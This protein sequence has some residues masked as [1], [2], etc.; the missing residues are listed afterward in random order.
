MS[1][2]TV[3]RR[4][5]TCFD[6]FKYRFLRLSMVFKEKQILWVFQRFISVISYSFLKSIQHLVFVNQNLI[7]VDIGENEVRDRPKRT[8]HSEKGKKQDL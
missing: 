7:N 8:S 1:G 3:V 6:R 5:S 2:M 4:S